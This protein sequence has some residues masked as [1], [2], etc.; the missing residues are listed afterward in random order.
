MVAEKPLATQTALVT[1]ASAGIG[2]ETAKTLAGDGA[3]VVLA[4]RR[5]RRLLSIASDIEAEHGVETIAVPTDVTD[6]T[7]VEA[8]VEAAID[9]FG[10]LD[11]VVNSA[12]TGQEKGLAIEEYDTEQYRTVMGV[13][14][15]GLFFTSRAAVPHLRETDG[16]L[17]FVGSL[18]GQYPRPGNP[19]YAASKWWTRG[20]ALSLA[21]QVGEDDVGVTIVNPTEVRT[22]F[23]K[24][25]RDELS[26]DQF[27]PGEVTEPE[28]VA[29]AIAFAARQEPPNTVAELDLYRRDVLTDL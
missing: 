29:E 18:A 11:V 3:N 23:A 4:A 9:R 26:K 12:G 15:D 28:E 6:E 7:D 24:E 2:R 14:T 16:I 10:Q 25:F 21:G 20:F 27:D 8:L 17:I 22:E 19:M 13:N 5:E 1:G